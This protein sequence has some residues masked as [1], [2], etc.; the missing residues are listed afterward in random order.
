MLSPDE[1]DRIDALVQDR[2]D[3]A[4]EIERD[5]DLARPKYDPEILNSD[6]VVFKRSKA[7][8]EFII[9]M[10]INTNGLGLKLIENIVKDNFDLVLR[11]EQNAD[12]LVFNIGGYTI[13]AIDVTLFPKDLGLTAM[14]FL[15]YL[16]VQTDYDWDMVDGN[17]PFI[18]TTMYSDELWCAEIHA[19]KLQALLNEWANDFDKP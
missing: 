2:L 19:D 8:R 16:V 1:L 12:P 5:L 3:N 11:Y 18:Y 13:G 15:D 4:L 14:Q 7:L 10:N 6:W 9:D 17:S